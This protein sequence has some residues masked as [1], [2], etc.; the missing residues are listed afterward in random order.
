MVRSTIKAASP[1][2]ATTTCA[3]YCRKSTDE[4]L[5][6]A[7]NSLDAQREKCFGYIAVQEH[8]GWV[9]YPE[10]FEDAGYSGGTLERPAL[11]RLL[12]EIQAGRVQCVVVYRADR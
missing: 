5:D 8:E 12:E 4:N 6:N 7:F 2:L 3:V 1:V 11:K 9:P 10:T